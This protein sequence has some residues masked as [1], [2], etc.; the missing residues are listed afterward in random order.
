ML[1][2]S[3]HDGEMECVSVEG[4]SFNTCAEEV[5][6]AVTLS[7]TERSIS[8]TSVLDDNGCIGVEVSLKCIMISHCDSNG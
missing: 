7:T 2:V 3:C 1:G 4:P 5:V 8:N 6:E